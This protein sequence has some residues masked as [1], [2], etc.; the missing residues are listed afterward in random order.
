MYTSGIQALV[1]QL[2]ALGRV[3]P[4]IDQVECIL[5]GLGDEYLEFSRKFYQ[6]LALYALDDGE[7]VGAAVR[8]CVAEEVK[9]VEAEVL[10]R[11]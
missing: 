7:L 2:A 6:G 10:G 1:S 4:N 11:C 3:I 9:I 8:S 5:R